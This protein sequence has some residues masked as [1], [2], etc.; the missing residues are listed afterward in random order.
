MVLASVAAR[1]KSRSKKRSRSAGKKYGGVLLE[2][3][4]YATNRKGREDDRL[5]PKKGGGDA[6]LRARRRES[7]GE[8]EYEQLLKERGLGEYRGIDH[9]GKKKKRRH[10]ASRKKKNSRSRSK[11]GAKK[12]SR[13]K[14]RR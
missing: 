4:K 3:E 6:T 7:E 12:R 9:S 13:S 11:S 10:S 8:D 2:D 14:S 1:V 5:G